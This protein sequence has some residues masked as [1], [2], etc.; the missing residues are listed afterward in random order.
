MT[1]A[2]TCTGCKATEH[3]VTERLAR[4]LDLSSTEISAL[5]HLLV[6][7]PNG[8]KWQAYKV[9]GELYHRQEQE[10]TEIVPGET[11]CVCAEH[12][13]N[14]NGET[15][16]IL[17]QAFPNTTVPEHCPCDGHSEYLE[18]HPHGRKSNG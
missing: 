12:D 14:G 13:C 11:K 7:A 15:G 18:D 3:W 4:Y 6:E 10:H 8:I 16:R 17:T 5:P 2:I 9:S 1:E